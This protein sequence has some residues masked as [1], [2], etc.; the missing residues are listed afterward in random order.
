MNQPNIAVVG[1]GMFGLYAAIFLAERGYQ[2][3]IF[4]KNENCFAEASSLN[5]ARIH[6]GYHYPRS[7]RTAYRCRASY[8]KFVSDFPNSVVKNDASF[9]L[10]SQG[11]KTSPEKF[12][13]I[14]KL[15]G[16]P[17]EAIP[18]EFAPL[19]QSKRILG[20]WKVDEASFNAAGLARDLGNRAKDVGVKIEYKREV[21]EIKEY[22]REYQIEFTDSNSEGDFIGV[23]NATYGD[24]LNSKENPSKSYLYEVCELV[25][26]QPT[27]NLRGVAITVMDGPFWSFTPWPKFGTSVLT[28]VRFTPHRRFLN[29]K[30]AQRFL[31]QEELVSRSELMLRDCISLVPSL[32][33]LEL[34][35]SRFVVKTIPRNRDLDD[36]RPIMFNFEERI[37][38][39][40][41]SKIDLI[42]DS[43]PILEEFMRRLND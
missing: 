30:D 41:G 19:F 9:Y 14:C 29:L 12:Q 20:K 5:Q 32:N 8:Q 31:S 6:G 36:S 40:T 25:Q 27:P 17:L 33:N 1:A 23:V 18:E 13:R 22:N 43:E 7:V 35:G 16:A 37:L 34:L 3:T 10:I 2:V 4:E 24:P 28:H 26:A 21:R 11:S 15:I 39:L 38:R 42:Y